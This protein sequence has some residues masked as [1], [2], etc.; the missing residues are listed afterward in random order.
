MND[1]SKSL[2]DTKNR[3]ASYI[4]RPDI[5]GMRGI[6]VSIVVLFHA[7]PNIITGGFIGVDIFFVISGYLITQIIIKSHN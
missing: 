6:A 2:N 3:E 4:Y 1:D 7:W 5:D